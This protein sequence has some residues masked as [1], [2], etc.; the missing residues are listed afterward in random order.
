MLLVI[1]LAFSHLTRGSWLTECGPLHAVPR[2]A[3]V[4]WALWWAWTFWVG[5]SRAAA[6]DKQMQ[7]LFGS[8]WEEYAAYVPWWFFPGLI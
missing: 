3:P 7:A 6:E 4:L 8:K 5:L 1:G 2:L